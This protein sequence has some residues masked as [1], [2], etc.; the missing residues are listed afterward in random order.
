MHSFI[1]LVSSGFFIFVREE[2]YFDY[3]GRGES[4]TKL[5]QQV[6]VMTLVSVIVNEGMSRYFFY[7]MHILQIK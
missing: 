4:I 1:V 2:V 7:F 6:V 3:F 5:R